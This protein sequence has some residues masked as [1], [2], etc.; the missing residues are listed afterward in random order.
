MI[1]LELLRTAGALAIGT[2][3]GWSFGLLQAAAQR[4]NQ[5]KETA[6]RVKSI[7]R[8]MPGSGQRVAYLLLALVLV[9]LVAPVVFAGGAQW[10][11]S[12]GLLLGYGLTLAQRILRLRRAAV[13][14]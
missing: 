13:H 4:Q 8:L 6:G 9:Q 5:E 7:W 1:V 14:E 12:G 10:W 2:G 11:V 3:I